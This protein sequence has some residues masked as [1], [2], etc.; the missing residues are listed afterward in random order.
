MSSIV[1]SRGNVT[2][3]RTKLRSKYCKSMISFKLD[4]NNITNKTIQSFVVK[5]KN[6]LVLNKKKI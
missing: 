1:F 4:N 2:Y 6:P 3:K 5:N